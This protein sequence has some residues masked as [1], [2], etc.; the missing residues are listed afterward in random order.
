MAFAPAS[1]DWSMVKLPAK[2]ATTYTVGMFVYNDN[3][4][5]VPTVAATQCNLKGIVQE[6]RASSTSTADIHVLVPNSLSSTFYGD[7]T[8]GETLSKANEG[9]PFDFGADGITISTTSTYDTVVLEK[10]I[11][12]TKG[13][14]RLNTTYG[15]EN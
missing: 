6:Y 14:F 15:I 5:N 8:A 3:T 4:D 12:T 10:F 11:S 7:M 9:D 1:R 2:A 13:I